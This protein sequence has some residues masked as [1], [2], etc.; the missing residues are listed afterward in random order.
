PPFRQAE[1]D[2]M[3][4]EGISHTGLLIDLGAE[5][6]IVDKSGAWYSYG[7]TRLGQGRENA[8]AFLRENAEL[9]AEIEGKVRA[10]L[11]MKKAQAASEE[12]EEASED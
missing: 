11:G 12:D 10:E 5:L 8:K 7:E 9:A 6:N 2:I 3:Y 1:F 4:N